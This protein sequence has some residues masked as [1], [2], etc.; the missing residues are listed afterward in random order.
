MST[1][2]L[3]LRASRRRVLLGRPARF[4]LPLISALLLV[5]LPSGPA[6]GATDPSTPPTSTTPVNPEPPKASTGT[7]EAISGTGATLTASIT[8]GGAA[9][10][11]RFEYGTTNTYGLTTATATVPADATAATVKV[12]ITG[13][14]TGTTYHFRVV[15]T[16]PAG[17]V[18]GSDRTFTTV[19]SPRAPTISTLSATKITASGAQLNARVNPQG[20]ATA[21]RFQWGLTTQYG[22]T[23]ADVSAGSGRGTVS[24]AIPVAALQAGTTY[25]FRA[26]AQNASGTVVGRDRT[27]T[28]SRGLTAVSAT[29]S[30]PVMRW[31]GTLTVTGTLAGAAPANVRLELMRLD[32]PYTGG[33]RRVGTMVTGPTGAYSVTLSRVFSAVR[34]RVR[35][36]GS[37]TILSPELPVASELLVRTQVGVR[38][39]RTTRLRGTVFPAT[40]AAVAT[41]QRQTPSGRW[42]RVKQLRLSARPGGRM[43]FRTVVRR[44]NRSAL[45]RVSVDPRDGGRH[46]LTTS[47]PVRI[48]ARR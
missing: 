20:Q 10:T 22:N 35:V 30:A 33:Y 9:T 29:L 48:A 43:S 26:V 28:V 5:L 21:V 46:V 24:R 42:V 12:P 39:A 1:L 31:N 32:Y 23:T 19:S 8:A 17:T 15:A 34:V 11:Y 4:A 14:T 6:T 38:K 18:Q 27:F 2:A 16:N 47:S 25:H 45:Y 37:N 44:L 3:R 41:L 13:L 40:T 36:A 7:A